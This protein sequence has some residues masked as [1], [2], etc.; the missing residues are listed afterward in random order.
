MSQPLRHSDAKLVVAWTDAV[1]A[2][3]KLTAF[4]CDLQEELARATAR[5]VKAE[6]ALVERLSFPIGATLTHEFETTQV[7]VSLDPSGTIVADWS[8]RGQNRRVVELLKE[9]DVDQFCERDQIAALAR[10][11]ASLTEQLEQANRSHAEL[12]SPEPFHVES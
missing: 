4:I 7:T 12:H 1:H 3:R 11:V 9:L 5:E 8:A 6:Q 2:T 10:H